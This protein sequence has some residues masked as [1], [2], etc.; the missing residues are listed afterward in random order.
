M[1]FLGQGHGI[2][3]N[4]ISPGPGNHK[5]SSLEKLLSNCHQIKVS[6]RGN[7]CE[8]VES[9]ENSREEKTGRKGLH[10]F[11]PGSALAPLGPKAVFSP[12]FPP[13]PEL[14]VQVL[15]STAAAAAM[16][17]ESPAGLQG[18]VCVVGVGGGLDPPNYPFSLSFTFRAIALSSPQR[19]SVPNTLTLFTEHLAQSC[20]IFHFP[21]PSPLVSAPATVRTG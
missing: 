18:H 10:C 12:V 8:R 1:A 19:G 16:L 11:L 15:D 5:T 14:H 13:M 21:Q 17:V 9:E 20:I 2:S 4:I 7:W 3:G 6:R